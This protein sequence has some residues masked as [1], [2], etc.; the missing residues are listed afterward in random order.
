MTLRL[1]LLAV[2]VLPSLVPNG[3]MLSR[4]PETNLVEITICSGTNHR[5]QFLDLDTG[6]YFA[7]MPQADSAES[8]VGEQQEIQLCPFSVTGLDDQITEPG[9][10]LL[11]FSQRTLF[12]QYQTAEARTQAISPVS[13]GPPDFL[14]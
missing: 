4:N 9:L 7:E 12:A 11:G 13:R 3:Y 2:F 5:V 1:M 6:N 10:I 8:D 14:S